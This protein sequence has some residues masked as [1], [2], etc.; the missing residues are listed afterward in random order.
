MTSLSVRKEQELAT[1]G[2]LP[3]AAKLGGVWTFDPA[4]VQAWIAAEELRIV[5]RAERPRPPAF[6]PAKSG[7]YATRPDHAIEEEFKRLIGHRPRGR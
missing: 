6:A 4:K 3:G 1:A 2:R 5:R 7:S